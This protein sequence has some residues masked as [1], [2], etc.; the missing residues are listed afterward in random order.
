MRECAWFKMTIRSSS[1]RRSVPTSL[2]QIAFARGGC[3][4]LRRIRR[5]Q[6]SNTVSNGEVNWLPR[7]RMRN[8]IS[9]RRARILM[10]KFRACWAVHAPSG[11]AVIPARRTRRV[12]CSMNT[13][14]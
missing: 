3:G 10:A 6:S 2:S 7:S 5:P 9:S 12:A 8:L 13:N 1:S 4:G 14:T 11:F